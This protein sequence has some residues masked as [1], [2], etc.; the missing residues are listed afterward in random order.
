MRSDADDDRAGK[1]SGENSRKRINES[2][3]DSISSRFGNGTVLAFD[4]EHTKF[5]ARF[6]ECA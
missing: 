6:I 3:P 2:E 4:L 5:A 1:R